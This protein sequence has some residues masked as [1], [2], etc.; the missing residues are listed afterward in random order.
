MI[1]ILAN[2]LTDGQIESYSALFA[3]TVA[4]LIII[5]FAK[6][7]RSIT[8]M[9]HWRRKQKR[10]DPKRVYTRGEKDK[11]M[12]RCNKRC[13]GIHVFAR[14]EY[15][16]SDLQGDHWF[17]HSRGGKTSIQNLVMLCPSCNRAKSDK[18]PTRLQTYAIKMRRKSGV[19]Y[20]DGVPLKVGEWIPHFARLR[21]KL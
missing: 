13:E 3:I 7:D 11:A 5:L 10:R 17:P 9:M 1:E 18:I 20:K 19:D 21:G 14:C 15:R 8:A 2:N 6:I 4:L 16:G 12:R